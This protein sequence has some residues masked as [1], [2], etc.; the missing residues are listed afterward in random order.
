MKTDLEVCAG[1]IESVFAAQ[2]GGAYRVELCS[3][4]DE[5]GIT[6]SVGFVEA[7]LSVPNLKKNVLIRPRG[8]DFLYTNAE[9]KV[10]LRD[11]EFMKSLGVDGVVIGAL[12]A[13]GSIDMEAM[14]DFM[15]AASGIDVT[16]HRAF[17][18]CRNPQEGL[19]QI[20]DLGCKRILTSGQAATA[21][22][23]IPV[24][25]ELVSAANHRISIMPGC[26]VNAQNAAEIIAKTGAVEI[27][28]SARAQLSSLMQFRIGGVGMG[29]SGVDEYARMATSESKVS[30]IVSA[31][32]RL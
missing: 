24:L 2:Q 28:A 7:A 4:L 25:N 31:L 22:Q 14:R 23:G 27:H 19:E 30:D 13:D 6:P 15:E 29:K 21:E 17:D 8:G 9:K 16:F 26:G 20:I 3:G 10:I 18:L 5:G 32:N 1:C 11:I 12:S